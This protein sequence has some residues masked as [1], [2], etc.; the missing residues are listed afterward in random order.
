MKGR[1]VCSFTWVLFKRGEL[2]QHF[3]GD[4]VPGYALYTATWGL[5]VPGLLERYPGNRKMA[6]QVRSHVPHSA[7]LVSGMRCSAWLIQAAPVHGS[8]P[9]GCS[10]AR[11][12]LLS[13]SWLN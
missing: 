1:C 9:C 4:D 8:W 11:T 2:G 12:M 13:S 5:I 10:Y 3:E 6:V 7:A